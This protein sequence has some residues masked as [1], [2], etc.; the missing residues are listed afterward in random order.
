[1][2]VAFVASEIAAGF[3]N[4]IADVSLNWKPLPFTCNDFSAFRASMD[5][6]RVAPLTFKSL[7]TSTMLPSAPIEDISTSL[8]MTFPVKF[9]FSP[10]TSLNLATS[11]NSHDLEKRQSSKLTGPKNVVPSVVISNSLPS[12]PIIFIPLELSIS[13]FSVDLM[14]FVSIPSTNL[15]SFI[16]IFP[17][18]SA[19]LANSFS[20]N[21]NAP[22]VPA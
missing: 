10:M 14:R 11:L 7:K 1:M 19:I 18:S 16:S 4:V 9:P 8:N 21:L 5:S 12:G 6:S 20:P 3:S 13:I 2:I 15:V 22:F 17:V